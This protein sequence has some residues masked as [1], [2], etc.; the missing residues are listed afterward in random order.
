MRAC[1]D[2]QAAYYLVGPNAW[3]GYRRDS[4]RR[5]IL[6]VR[7]PTELE[8]EGRVDNALHVPRGILESGACTGDETRDT[9]LCNAK[10]EGRVHL[11]CASGAHAA[12]AADTLRKMGYDA[13]VIDGGMATWK[14]ADLPVTKQLRKN[15][16]S[17]LAGVPNAFQGLRNHMFDFGT[18]ADEIPSEA[19]VN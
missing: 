1:R 10:N 18:E 12:L 3:F 8:S 14:N 11:V 9:A 17:R 7:E 19:S 5:H 2:Q 13:T 4:P 6:G 16:V 15:N